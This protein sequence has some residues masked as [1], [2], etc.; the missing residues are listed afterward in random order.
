MFLENILSRR[1]LLLSWLYIASIDFIEDTFS[2]PI[3]GKILEIS[4]FRSL[5]LRGIVNE[6]GVHKDR[7]AVKMIIY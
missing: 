2:I 3:V 1:N 6:L 5:G 7:E 4:N